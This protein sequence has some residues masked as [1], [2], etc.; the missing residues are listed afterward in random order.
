MKPLIE[1]P[2][3]AAII[4]E[5]RKMTLMAGKILAVAQKRQEADASAGPTWMAVSCAADGLLAEAVKNSAAG[6]ERMERGQDEFRS[7]LVRGQQ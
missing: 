4:A 2:I 5:G 3:L 1:Y 7:L 6:Y